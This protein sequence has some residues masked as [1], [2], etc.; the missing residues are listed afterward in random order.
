MGAARKV[1]T[2]RDRVTSSTSDTLMWWPLQKAPSPSQAVKV[3][4]THANGP[5]ANST[6]AA[7][8]GWPLRTT[9]GKLQGCRPP[10]Y[11]NNRM[12]VALNQNPRTSPGQLIASC[13]N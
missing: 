7:A 6:T 3:R 4:V 11:D 2:S 12:A 13:Q 1:P 8:T 9:A 5:P 10:K